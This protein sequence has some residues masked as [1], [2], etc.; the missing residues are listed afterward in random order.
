MHS[1]LLIFLDGV[2][3]GQPDP[4][5][6]PFFKYHFKFLNDIFGK[7]PSLKNQYLSANG[8]YLFPTDPLLGVEGLPQSGTGQT[9]IFCGVNAPQIAGRHFGPFPHSTTIQTLKEKNI[10][11]EFRKRKLKSTFVNAYPKVFFDYIKS[12]KTRLSTTTLSCNLSNIPLH[13]T[14]DVRKGKA[15]TAEITA[16]RWVKKLNY[17][18]P[19]IKPETAAR[20][21][22]RIASQN[23]FTAYE[24]F[25]TDHL[26][27]WRHKEEM[28]HI[29]DV[30][31]RF[32]FSLMT[33][34]DRKKTTLVIC[35][36]HG[37]LEDLS[38][39]IHTMNPALTITAGKYA[40]ELSESIKDLTQI[41]PA[42]MKLY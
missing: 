17:K 37:N 21:L 9:S 41:K 36:D 4:S 16:E 29:L 8:N 13:K 1:T 28:E 39:K 6:N 34:I 31:D 33:N 27:H 14:E 32:L 15:L 2:G 35:S 26:G 3:I 38:V 19:I 20:R 24:Y 30:L 40:K 7:P 25:L 22:L 23:H 18:L 11:H 10:F 12:G 5:S 42:I